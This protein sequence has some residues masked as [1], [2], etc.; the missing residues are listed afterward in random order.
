MKK[1]PSAKFVVQH[2]AEKPGHWMKRFLLNRFSSQMDGFIFSSKGI[3]DEWIKVRAISP[4][5]RFA[6]I[7]E[8]SSDFLYDNRSE[9]RQKTGLNGNPVLLWVGRLNKNKDP[10][11]ILS[12]F[13]KLI[14]DFPEA[15]LYMIYSE[16][17]LKPKIDLMIHNSPLL[18]EKVKLL[19]FVNYSEIQHYYNSADYFVLG[20]HYEGSGFSLV[21]AM[22]CGVV[23]IVTDIP[24]FRMM[25][26]NGSVGTLW[27]C[28]DANSFYEK[29]KS[30][31]NKPI[32]NETGRT[33]KFFNYNL[34]YPAIGR[35]AKLF[36]ESLL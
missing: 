14:V 10:L 28:G 18:I 4:D 6:E 1:N 5:Q 30:I 27:K 20:S 21:E 9:A 16:D 13:E 2:H 35:N 32:K 33:L 31:I 29:A 24:S 23:P 36:Y 7:M 15:R 34:S 26:N 19:G 11:T 3:Y 25:T 12:G 8:G 17:D 22:S